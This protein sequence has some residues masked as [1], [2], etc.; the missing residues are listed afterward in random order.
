DATAATDATDSDVPTSVAAT[1]TT[2]SIDLESGENDLTWDA[3]VYQLLSLGNRVWEDENNNGQLDGGESGIDGVTVRLYRDLNGDGDVDDAGETTP[4][5]T[6][7][8]GNGGYYLFSGLVQGDYLVEV[9]LPGGYVSSTG[10]NGS[11]SGL[12]EPAP[13]ADTNN[14]DSDD[15]GTQSG[16]VVRSTIVRLRPNTEPTDETDPLPGAISDPARNENSNLTVDFGLFRPARLGD[17]VWFDRDANG[18]QNGG[19]ETGISEVQVQLFRDADGDGQP[20]AGDTLIATVTT[21]T[22]GNYSFDY[23]IP[24]DYYVVFDVP[25]GY[26]RSPQD[27]GGNDAID[28]DPDQTSGATEVTSLSSG[29]TDLTWDAGLY[30][31]VNLGNQV[32]ND[33]NNNGLLDSGESGIDGVTV[34]L[35]YDANRNGVIDGAENTPFATVTTSG[36]GFYNFTELDPGNYLVEVPASNFAAGGPLGPS[37]T[38]PAFSSSTGTNGSATGPYEGTATPDPDNNVDNDDNGTTDSSGNVRAA[39]ITLRSQDE[40][41]TDGDG[42]NGNL[43]LDFGF[44]RP[45]ALG[46][47]V[48]HDY[49]NNRTADVGEPGID[50]VTVE[51]YRDTNGNG[52]YDG[53]STDTLVATTTTASGGFYRFD[54]LAPGDYI[55]VIPVSN[56][57]SGGALRFFRSSDDGDVDDAT[58]TLDPDNDADNDDNGIGPNVPIMTDTS[59]SVA[60]QAITLSINGEPTAEDGNSNTNLTVDFG[61]Y[62]LTVGNR[63]WIDNNNNGVFDAGD[64]NGG[65]ANGRTVRLFYDANGNGAID[66]SETTLIASFTTSNN[67]RY[68]FGGLRDGGSYAI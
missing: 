34:N 50:G 13:N 2:I 42:N 64:I 21:D 66:G 22:T 48:W 11:A 61:F 44:F 15:N 10:T 51:L 60:S 32:W 45:L 28:S 65:Y 16:S 59:G 19:D 7:I 9:V 4:V 33:V 40:P 46:N 49:N 36:G 29:Q 17:L 24:G 31:R 62:S 30:Q 52:T 1:A 43:T 35:Y 38:M 8:T 5:V 23:L 57:G 25:T 67:G 68:L 6:T 37:G 63:V 3:G 55:V 54:N 39:M 58:N 47:F 18:V 56:F 41:T 12:Y 26:V 27:Q 14:T 20:S 53:A